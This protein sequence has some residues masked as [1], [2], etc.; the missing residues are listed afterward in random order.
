M[1]NLLLLFSAFMFLWSCSRSPEPIRLGVESCAHC[2]MTIVD[3]K[4]AAELITRK[5]KIYKFDSVECLIGYQIES[6]LPA[7]TIHSQWVSDFTHPGTFIRAETAVYLHSQQLKSPM[8]LNLAA[9][10]DEIS[11]KEYQKKLQG[12]I[13]TWQEVIDLIPAKTHQMPK[14][15]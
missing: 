5:G 13:L 7:E 8:G 1:K 9:F 14:S 12:H 4:F 11:A 3:A 2:K 6:A 15:D 10:P